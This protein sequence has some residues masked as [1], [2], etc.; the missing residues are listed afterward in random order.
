MIDTLWLQIPKQPERYISIIREKMKYFSCLDKDTGELIYEFST[1]KVEGTHDSTLNIK[2]NRDNTIKLYG[3]VHKIIMGN[4]IAYGSDNILLLAN[5]MKKLLQQKFG[6]K[7]PDVI[8]WEVKQ[9]DYT[10]TFDLKDDKFVAEYINSYKEVTYPRRENIQFYKDR[11]FYVPGT[12]TTI[13]LY[14]KYREF[15]RHDK[16]KLSKILSNEK[17]N[18][19]LNLSN[20]MLRIEVAVKSKKLKEVFPNTVYRKTVEKQYAK[21]KK[22]YGIGSQELESFE[23]DFRRNIV[24]LQDI[25]MN[26]IKKVWES[27]V[28]KLTRENRKDIVNKSNLVIERLHDEYGNRSANSLYGFWILLSTKGE[29]HAKKIYTGKDN[30]VTTTFYRNRKKL[31]NAGIS[32]RETD[33]IIVNKDNVVRFTPSLKLA[34]QNNFNK[35]NF[36]F[37][38]KVYEILQAV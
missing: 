5:V 21:A 29:E 17:I 31:V 3:S 22:I 2:I 37:M 23:R 12:T 14:N 8:T 32:W 34:E 1:G 26:K 38:N 24:T 19:L 35:P 33:V 28:F 16:N 30:K 13:K 10:L 11:S 15:I 20:G 9:I 18:Q 7:L 27:E 36:E 4:N 25:K 6:F